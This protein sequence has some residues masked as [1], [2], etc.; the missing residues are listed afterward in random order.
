M[1]HRRSSHGSRRFAYQEF[2]TE[3]K[4]LK[5]ETLAGMRVTLR[6][7][8]EQEAEV[9]RLKREQEAEAERI[10]LE[11]ARIER[12]RTELAKLQQELADMKAKQAAEAEAERKRLDEIRIARRRKP[13]A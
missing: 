2:T 12:E 6:R 3:A 11:S 9:A 10:K 1:K 4:R 7:R 5:E 13:S 8:Q